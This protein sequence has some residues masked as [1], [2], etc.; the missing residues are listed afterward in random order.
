MRIERIRTLKEA[1]KIIPSWHNITKSY[2]TKDC[3][4]LPEWYL[5]Y[6][7]ILPPSER[8]ELILFYEEQLVGILPVCFVKRG[9]IQAVHIMGQPHFIGRSDFIIKAGYEDACLSTFVDWLKKKRRWHIVYFRNFGLFSSNPEILKR[10]TRQAKF[11]CDTIRGSANRFLPLNQYSDIENYLQSMF[12]GTRRHSF[13]KQERRL[14]KHSSF[15]WLIHT[16]KAKAPVDELIELDLRKQQRSGLPGK[17][18]FFLPGKRDYFQ[19]VTASL[20]DAVD[21]L[22]VTLRVDG[23]DAAKI[24]TFQYDKK[25]F[26][27]LNMFDPSYSKLSPGLQ[28]FKKLIELAIQSNVEE[29]D[30]MMG[31]HA[32]TQK[33]TNHQRQGM[34]LYILNDGVLSNML[35]YY[36]RY[37]KPAGRTVKT[38]FPGLHKRWLRFKKLQP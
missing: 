12:T 3:L 33:F 15:E 32:Y 20:P 31:D 14:T 19:T 5:A 29:L 1:K 30:F 25:L 24:I 9:L 23:N 36:Y 27:Y 13:R 16:D 22:G 6:W 34:H 11:R 8:A 2:Q 10:C 28:N 26:C 7:K 4:L 18:Y 17:C 38:K 35:D 37:I 21:L